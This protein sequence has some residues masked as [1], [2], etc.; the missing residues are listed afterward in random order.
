MQYYIMEGMICYIFLLMSL[1]HFSPLFLSLTLSPLY[2]SLTYLLSF[3][4]SLSLT[5]CHSAFLISAFLSVC[6]S[7]CPS[8]LKSVPLSLCLPVSLSLSLSGLNRKCVSS[9]F[10]SFFSFTFLI[11]KLSTVMPI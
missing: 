10:Y 4:L 7:V 8:V 11:N 1:S 2:L 3:F 6:L 9:S 5:F